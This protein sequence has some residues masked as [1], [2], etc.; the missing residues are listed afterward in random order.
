MFKFCSYIFTK[1]FVNGTNNYTLRDFQHE[2]L[3]QQS[4]F[5]TGSENYLSQ[6]PK[7]AYFPGR[8]LL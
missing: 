6:K 1:V 5:G 3:N 8:T 2:L 7:S 4:T